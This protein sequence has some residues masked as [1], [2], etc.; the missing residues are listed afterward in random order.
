M[1]LRTRKIF[2][3]NSF[4]SQLSSLCASMDRAVT[5]PKVSYTARGW[6]GAKTP[7]KDV[8]LWKR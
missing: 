4:Y 8:A 7:R 3:G 2:P 6:E 1:F 5:N